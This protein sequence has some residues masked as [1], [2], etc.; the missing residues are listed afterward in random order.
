MRTVEPPPT[1]EELSAIGERHGIAHLGIAP[2][3][4]MERAR[5]A[6]VE[7][8]AAGLHGTMAF[9]Y[10][11]PER[12]TDP[13]RTLPTA[14]SAIVCAR[15]Y[16]TGSPP[17][18]ER[19]GGRVALYAQV[20]HYALLREGLTAIAERLRAA[21]HRAVVLSDDN[22]LVDREIAYRAGLGWFGKNANLLISG[23]GSFFVLGCVL[24]DAVYVAD[25]PVPDGC[26][27]CVRCLAG[28]P[29]GAIVAPGV[30]DA[31]RCLAWLLQQGG[32]FPEQYREALGDRMYGC[33]DC[34]EVCPPTVRLSGRHRPSLPE[35]MAPEP[36]VDLQFF[37]TASDEELLARHGRWYVADRDPRWWRRNALV[38]LGN[39]ATSDD[40]WVGPEL[41]RY[42]TGSDPIL[43]E[44]AQWAQQRLR[45]R[46]VE[47]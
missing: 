40:D 20:D 22:A 16:A 23:A 1:R 42:A 26:G 28:C 38:V 21:G 24:T 45:A 41:E 31:A 27:G 12:S 46:G 18:A 3:T 8:R 44:H 7:R 17:A 13:R 36:W 11:N 34:Q 47:L 15:S 19:I 4:V 35:G 25:Q 6:L 37:L 2:A 5:D 14:E 10:R 30:V 33:D 39:T 43:A 9:T 29:T 32:T